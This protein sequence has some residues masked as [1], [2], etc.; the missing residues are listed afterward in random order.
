MTPVDLLILLQSVEMI[1]AALILVPLARSVDRL[2]KEV[3]A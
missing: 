1:G 3:E 2:L